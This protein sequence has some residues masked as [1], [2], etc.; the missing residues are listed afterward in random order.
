MLNLGKHSIF[1]TALF[2]IVL[3][4][5]IIHILHCCSSTQ[6]QCHRTGDFRY[7]ISCWS[8]KPPWEQ[9][10]D[11]S[12]ETPNSKKELPELFAFKHLLPLQDLYW[13]WVEPEDIVLYHACSTG[14]CSPHHYYHN[15][16]RGIAER[17]A[18]ASLQQ[19]I[20]RRVVMRDLDRRICLFPLCPFGRRIQLIPT[21][22]FLVW[23]LRY[24]SGGFFGV[25]AA[26]LFCQ[27]AQQ[28]RSSL[29]WRLILSTSH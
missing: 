5:L 12:A 22:Y 25:Q 28:F 26:L 11:L 29:Q 18:G 24:I 10:E 8:W 16:C 21:A 27:G 14:A 7:K 20:Q 23:H 9:N 1:K 3:V 6:Q 17:I 2:C 13:S 15:P 4:L 19:T